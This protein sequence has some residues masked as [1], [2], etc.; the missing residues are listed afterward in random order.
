MKYNPAFDGLRAIAVLSVVALHAGAPFSGGAFVGV[1]LFFVLSGFLITTLL[2]DEM[3]RTGSIALGTFYARRAIRLYPTLVLVLAAFVATAPTLWPNVPRW[4]HAAIAALYLSDYSKAFWDAPQVIQHTWSLA[5]E[6]HFYLVMPLVLPWILRSRNPVRLLMAGY[7]IATIWRLINAMEFGWGAYYRFDTRL[8]GLLLGCLLAV[9]RPKI[10]AR[11]GWLALVALA[12]LFTVPGHKT[13][14][15]LTV[16]V[17]VAEILSAMLIVVAANGTGIANMTRVRSLAYTGKL[18][19]GIYL[20]HFPIMMAMSDFSWSERLVLGGVASFALAAATYHL[21]DVP[22]KHF[23][24]RQFGMRSTL[25]PVPPESAAP[26]VT[27]SSAPL[28]TS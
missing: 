10:E 13:V 16:M 1:D 12:I 7:L 2:A 27:R 5:V 6:E 21:I 20:W 3:N 15:G 17:T 28:S 24:E 11:S 9:W 22:L 23:R 8:S 25:K 26:T 19:Y 18:S 4:S 14:A